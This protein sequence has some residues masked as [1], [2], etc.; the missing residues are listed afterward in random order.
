MATQ[1][2]L[3]YEDWFR[4][5]N[6]GKEASASQSE[7]GRVGITAATI[8]RLL[9]ASGCETTVDAPEIVAYQ[10]IMHAGL[11]YSRP[12]EVRLKWRAVVDQDTAELLAG[13]VQALIDAALAEAKGG[14]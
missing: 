3:T 6:E 14:A 4:L 8:Q 5:H 12:S 1:S 7:T 2:K 13:A 11:T 10:T 9:V